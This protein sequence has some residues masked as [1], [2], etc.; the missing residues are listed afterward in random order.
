MKKKVNQVQVAQQAARELFFENGGSLAA[1]RGRPTRFSNK[2]NAARKNA[3]RG[4][5]GQE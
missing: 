2:K 4:K 3:C 5:N 1:Y